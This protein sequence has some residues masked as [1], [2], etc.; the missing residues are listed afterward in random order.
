MKMTSEEEVVYLQDEL[1]AARH[2]LT[3]CQTECS[4][5]KKLLSRKVHGATSTLCTVLTQ[6][7]GKLQQE[8]CLKQEAF[9]QVDK[10]QNQVSDMEAAFS[11]CTSKAGECH[12]HVSKRQTMRQT[13]LVPVWTLNRPLCPIQ[14]FSIC[15]K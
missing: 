3:C 9:Q 14:N 13:V 10:L 6:V 8:R 11:R 15:F 2:V 12:A 7:K 1:D 4:S 5:A